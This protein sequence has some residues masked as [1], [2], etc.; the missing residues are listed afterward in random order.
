MARK[1]VKAIRI[2][3]E[4]CKR[5]GVCTAFCPKNVFATDPEGVVRIERLDACIACEI[6]ERM[7]PDLAISL[8]Y[9]EPDE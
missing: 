4:W 3:Q 5:C 2:I 7:C 9:G 6:C 1:Q 8:E